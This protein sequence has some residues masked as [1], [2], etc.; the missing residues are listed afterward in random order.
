MTAGKASRSTNYHEKKNKHY[1]SLAKKEKYM[2]V[3][4]DACNNNIR[5][6]GAILIQINSV[7][8]QRVEKNNL[9]NFTLLYFTRLRME[10]RFK[11]CNKAVKLG[12]C[13]CQFFHDKDC[14]DFL[15]AHL[16]FT[17]YFAL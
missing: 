7:T 12:V 5:I 9:L 3:I 16:H 1:L 11:S 10:P 13:K 2:C 4:L 15:E 8:T 14:V 17:G 6:H